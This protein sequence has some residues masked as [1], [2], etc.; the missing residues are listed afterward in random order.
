MPTPK[1]EEY[2]NPNTELTYI[3]ALS[4][5]ITDE[6]RYVGK[7]VNINYRFNIHLLNA[8]KKDTYKDRW[9]RTLLNKNLKPKFIILDIVNTKEWEF[10]EIYWISLLKSWN[11][12]LTNHQKG[13]SIGVASLGQK[14][15]KPHQLKGKKYADVY[16]E[17]KA[18]NLRKKLSEAHIGLQSGKNHPMYGKKS[19]DKVKETNSIVHSKSVLQYDQVNNLIKEWNSIAEA[20]KTLGITHISDCCIGKNMTAGG[21][22]WRHKDNPI[23]FPVFPK[24]KIVLQFT[25]Q[26]IFIKEYKN[27]SE[28]SNDTN[29]NRNTIY[30]VLTNIGD[31][32]GGYIWKY[33]IDTSNEPKIKV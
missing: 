16:G 4:D 11:F 12:R 21:F 1:L 28:A 24:N 14:K 9:I 10:W 5:P 15:S 27:L 29:I 13:G 26:N 19:S 22:I 6:I 33:K 3:Y 2:N 17:E 18:N 30:N 20:T 7:S 31:T 25:K 8:L 32:A 23:P